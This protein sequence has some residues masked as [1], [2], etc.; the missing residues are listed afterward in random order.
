MIGLGI[1]RGAKVRNQKPTFAEK[2]HANRTR[3]S[4][5]GPKSRASP[6]KS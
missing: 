4:P 5:F 1:V 6:W 3:P 2:G